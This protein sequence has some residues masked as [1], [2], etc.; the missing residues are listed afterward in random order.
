VLA[1]AAGSDLDVTTA[2]DLDSRVV[3]TCTSDTTVREAALMMME[4]YIRHLL[5]QGDTGLIGVVSARDL[6]GAH[7]D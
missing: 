6:L 1:V 3:I 7:L 5:V 2:A 4:H